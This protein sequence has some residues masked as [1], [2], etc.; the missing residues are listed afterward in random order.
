MTAYE[1]LPQHD[2][3]K[4]KRQAERRIVLICVAIVLAVIAL[5]TYATKLSQ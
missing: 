3:V 4:R 5:V 1:M 2:P